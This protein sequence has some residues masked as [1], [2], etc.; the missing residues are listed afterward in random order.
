MPHGDAANE[1]CPAATAAETGAV[2]ADQANEGR[3]H[4]GKSNREATWPMPTAH[5]QMDQARRAAGKKPDAA[6]LGN[7][8]IVPRLFTSALG[9]EL[10]AWAHAIGGNSETRL[11]RLLLGTRKIPSAYYLACYNAAT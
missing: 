6:V 7:A 9:G 10:S 11:R 2:L 1:S 8:Q 3:W 4:E 5:R